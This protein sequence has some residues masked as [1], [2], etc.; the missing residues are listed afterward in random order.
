M[1]SASNGT[2][3]SGGGIMQRLPRLSTPV[4]LIIIV[5][6]VLVAAIPMAIT[7]AD[8]TAKQGPL[9]QSLS[10]LQ[11]QN[12]DLQKQL[13]SKGSLT[14]QINALKT[15][16]EAAKG[17]YGNACDSIE[18]SRDLINMAWQYDI[19]I[20]SMSANP[21]KSKIAGKD[22][23]GTSYVLSMSGQVSNFQNFLIAL[24]N[25]FASS[26]PADILVLPAVQE[27]TLDHATLTI[28]VICSQ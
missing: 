13:S 9:R 23:S 8:E 11:A 15:E 6:L 17:H 7:Y 28:T 1:I 4:W 22:Y 19:T 2:K 21:V 16:V 10:K 25:R 12:A 24:G 18:T 3:P 27:G 26:Q 20:V 5:A 14:T